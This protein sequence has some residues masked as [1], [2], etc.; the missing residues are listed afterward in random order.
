MEMTMSNT[1]ALADAYAGLK[2][3]ADLIEARIKTVR[4]E[5][6]SVGDKEIVGDTCI[7]ALI[8]KKGA[9]TLDKDAALAL[10]RQLGATEEQI[11]SLNKVGKA[12]T[13]LQIK[14]KLALA[15]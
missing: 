5:I 6:L 2:H 4:A 11:A 15:I 3:E 9:T 12:S 10:L 13:S 14:P 7:V 8:E 1:A